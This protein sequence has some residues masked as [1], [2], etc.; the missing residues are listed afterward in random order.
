MNYKQ[1]LNKKVISKN[2]EQ[3]VVTK[4]DDEHISIKYLDKEITYNFEISLKNKFLI[5]ADA[6]LQSL[7][8]KYLLNEEDKK[9]Q[10]EKLFE[11][12]NKIAIKRNKTITEQHKKLFQKYKELCFLFGKDFIYPP[13]KEFV[14]KYR[15]LI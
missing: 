4:F 6:N 7:I 11:D 14:K 3:G 2:N 9:L 1:F 10:K 15:Y 8:D 12:N 13:Y 5:F